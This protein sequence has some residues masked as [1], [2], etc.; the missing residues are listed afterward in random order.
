MRRAFSHIIWHTTW[1]RSILV[2]AGIAECASENVKLIMFVDAA[3][4]DEA[5]FPI[6]VQEGAVAQDIA[7]EIAKPDQF[8]AAMGEPI[9]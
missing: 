4:Y 7:C 6:T 8:L 5:S 2:Q 1:T 9:S 3:S